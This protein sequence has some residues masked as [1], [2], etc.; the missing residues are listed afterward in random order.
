MN[1]YKSLVFREWKLSQKHYISKI[2]LFLL[3]V[4]MF[5]LAMFVLGGQAAEEE[6][7]LDG[8]ALLIS[9][10]I[11]IVGVI[12]VAEDNGV[13]KADVN[14]GWLAYSWALPL[15]AFEKAMAKYILKAVV[16]VVGM[17]LII[18]GAVVLYTIAGC[19]ISINTV[20]SFFLFLDGILIYDM[21]RQFILMYA[22]DS[23]ALKKMGSIASA[24]GVALLFLPDLFSGG[25]T[26]AFDEDFSSVEGLAAFNE[27]TRTLVIPTFWGCAGVVF[28]FVLLIVGFVMTWKSYER[29][30]A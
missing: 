29:R 15:T 3:F 27:M 11:G 24:V 7:T 8:F 6:T 17:T 19:T 9:Y 28:M 23:K 21:V 5:G 18:L 16:I 4:V 14:S 13:Y 20:L 26:D 2:L 10:L 1:K 25:E 12:Y 30:L 22:T